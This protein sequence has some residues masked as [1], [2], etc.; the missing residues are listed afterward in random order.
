MASENTPIIIGI[1]QVCVR[2]THEFEKISPQSLRREAT[3]IAL[4][5][6]GAAEY[7]RVSIDHIIAV[8][9][10]ADSVPNIP[11]PFGRCAA[12]AATVAQQ[13]AIPN[14]RSTYSTVGG[15]QPQALVNE[16]S[17]AIFAGT[18]KA[19]LLTGSE[20]TATFKYAL[21]NAFTLDWS[22]SYGADD[23]RGFGDRLLSSYEFCNGL[24]APTLTYPAFEHA[25]RKRWGNTREQHA[26]AMAE[27]WT[28][29]SK[30]ASENPNAQYPESLDFAFLKTP[31][32]ANYPIADPYLKWHVAQ[33]AVNQGAALVLTS[34]GEAR[35]AGI[36]P[37]KWIFL[38]GYA[39][40]K[41]SLV[42][43]RPDLSRS[44]AM[45][46]ALK[47]ALASANKTVSEIDFLDLYSC[48]PCAVFL[49]AEALGINPLSRDLTV[50]GGLPF[51]GGAGNNY[52]M[53]AIASMVEKLRAKSGSYGLVLANG[54]F[55]SKEAV[56]VYSTDPVLDWC[57][58]D[59]GPIQAKLD[60]REKPTLLSESCEAMIESY[61]VIY[62]KGI[63]KSCY[64]IAKRGSDRILARNHPNCGV[65]FDQMT[66]MDPIGLKAHIIHEDGINYVHAIE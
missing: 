42:G 65:L 10:M 4:Q 26:D 61:S 24:G 9:T 36:N 66:Q 62:T 54:G 31:S 48:F 52:S 47:A 16:A 59:S 29:F 7:F 32:A 53:H 33:D 41:D 55:L 44:D 56:G 23:D 37:N 15:D 39:E 30:I 27:I 57:P 1:G 49:A 64:V 6:T 40:A 45:E 50:T 22:E 60:G 51:F 17:E 3:E 25:L 43:E 38:H 8:R 58:C 11:Q 28:E 12:P 18:A 20:A 14:A 46:L 19:I 21:K 34:V 63:A 13:C 35:R 5:D 2:D